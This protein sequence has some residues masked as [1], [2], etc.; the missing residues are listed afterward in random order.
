MLASQRSLVMTCF[1]GHG[2]LRCCTTLVRASDCFSHM[3]L[4]AVRY[5]HT[6]YALFPS[7]MRALSLLRS[8]QHASHVCRCSPG[9]SSR[10][11]LASLPSQPS[12]RSWPWES[13]R[14]RRPEPHCRCG[15]CSLACEG[16]ITQLR[17]FFSIFSIFFTPCMYHVQHTQF[18]HEHTSIVFLHPTRP[19]IHPCMCISSVSALCRQ[20]FDP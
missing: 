12:T 14:G 2:Q 7:A 13:Q 1:C 18:V 6:H 8:P 20:R 10:R 19:S 4:V 16:A 15:H 3:H 11:I 17:V 9:P 5:K